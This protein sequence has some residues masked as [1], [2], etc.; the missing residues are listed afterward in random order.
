MSL[1]SPH[2]SECSEYTNRSMQSGYATLYHLIT[3]NALLEWNGPSISASATQAECHFA[4]L[5]VAQASNEP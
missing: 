4:H 3:H 2:Y 1:T 5:T